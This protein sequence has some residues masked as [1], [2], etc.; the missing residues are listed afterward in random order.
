MKA[1]YV[2]VGMKHQGSEALVASLKIGHP[3]LLVREP[4]N[5][6]DRNAVQV[7]LDAGAEMKLLGYVKGTQAAGLAR[8][9]DAPTW[10]Q[11][12]RNTGRPCIMGVLKVSGDR[13][14]MIEVE[15]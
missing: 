12:S 15:E 5:R 8:K 9:L 11:C 1:S 7:W 2:L 14:P 3:L 10:H 4:D 6:Y 13:W